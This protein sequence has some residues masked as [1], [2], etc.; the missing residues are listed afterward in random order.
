MVVF[1]LSYVIIHHPL[2]TYSFS[3]EMGRRVNPGGREELRG[4]EGGKTAIRIDYV[5]KKY[6]FKKR[7]KIYFLKSCL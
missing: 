2:E 4:A 7:E 6:I 3:N 5:R 1:V